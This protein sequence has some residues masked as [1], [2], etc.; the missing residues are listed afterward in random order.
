M[1][2]FLFVLIMAFVM[3]VYALYQLVVRKNITETNLGAL[4]FFVAFA[5]IFTPV[6][7]K[8]NEKQKNIDAIFTHFDGCD[9]STTINFKAGEKDSSTYRVSGCGNEYLMRMKKGM[10]VNKKELSD[11]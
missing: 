6:Y 4:V 1:K 2:S 5:S 7:L 8:G 9:E 10:V 11:N 3:I